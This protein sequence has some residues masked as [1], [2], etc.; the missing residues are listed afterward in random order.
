MTGLQ[1]CP[2]A[3]YRSAASFAWFCEIGFHF[4][5]RHVLEQREYC[6]GVRFDIRLLSGV[7]GLC[8]V[9][10]PRNRCRFA[11]LQYPQGF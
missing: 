10:P 11:A 8:G 1:A 3:D 9:H 4:I 7:C 2:G 6:G 5:Q